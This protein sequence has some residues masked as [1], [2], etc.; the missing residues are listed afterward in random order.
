MMKWTLFPFLD[1]LWED[2]SP[3]RL[4]L[5]IVVGFFLG[6]TPMLTLHWVLLA[7]LVFLLRINLLAVLGSFL[8]FQLCAAPMEP[9]FHKIGYSVLAE[10]PGLRRLW[11]WMYHAPVLAFLRFN[12]TVVMGS[13]VFTPLSFGPLYLASLWLFQTCGKRMQMAVATSPVGS[14]WNRS[15]LCRLYE[16]YKDEKTGK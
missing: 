1:A 16:E 8:F 6:L 12:N 11:A 7:G 14:A 4:A 3:N 15:Y 13:G 5:G 2:D 10:T 9:V